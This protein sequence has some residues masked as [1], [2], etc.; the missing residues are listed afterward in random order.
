MKK[1]SIAVIQARSSSKR[2]PKKIMKKL[3]EKPMILH[4]V[5]RAR[6]CR[7]VN[8]VIVATSTENSDNELADL[9][10]KNKINIIRG[11]LNNVF[12]RYIEAIERFPSDY[13]VRITG[14]CPFIHPEFIDK[15]IEALLSFDGDFVQV[16][17]KTTLLEGQGVFSTKSLKNIYKN[18]KN[19]D[20]LEHVGSKY[21]SENLEK[22]RIIKFE[23]PKYL[24]SE[25][26]RLTVDEKK[27]FELASL[28][29]DQIYNDEPFHIKDAISWLDEN[30]DIASINQ[31]ISHSKIN[32]DIKKKIHSS[33]INFCGT[34]IW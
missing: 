18:T 6:M 4:I 7:H 17:Q 5:E 20:D 28:L 33:A 11:S 1:K 30:P 10:Y 13:V 23:I 26:Y 32:K 22:F 15:Q 27:D 14:D 29:Y 12:E 2:L 31:S 25:K 8:K 19:L 21:I 3:A 16:S 24:Q 34:Y 9:C